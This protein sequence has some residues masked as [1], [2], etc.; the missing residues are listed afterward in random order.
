MW[1]GSGPEWRSWSVADVCAREPIM[2][3]VLD[4]C[5]REP[6]MDPLTG[7][8]N[9]GIEEVLEL[10]LEVQHA[11]EGPTLDPLWTHSGPTLDPLWTH[12]RP[13]LDPLWTHS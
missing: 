3:P 6:I 9:Q 13:I 12:S 1:S 7:V 2:D 10:G 4:V 8:V 11:L 5:M